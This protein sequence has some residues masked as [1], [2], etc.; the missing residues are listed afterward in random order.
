M[1]PGLFKFK[2]CFVFCLLSFVFC[3]L[4][5]CEVEP[6]GFDQPFFYFKDGDAFYWLFVQTVNFFV[7]E[8]FIS[9]Y[10][11]G[12]KF[13]AQSGVIEAMIG[14]EVAQLL[15]PNGRRLGS[16][17]TVTLEGVAETGNK[18]VK[19]VFVVSIK[20]LFYWR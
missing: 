18:L 11:T 3:L 15:F 8:D 2:T 7:V 1:R 13:G 6:G 17:H 9:Q 14:V 20:L 16:G 10:R 4:S 12:D 19:I 5:L